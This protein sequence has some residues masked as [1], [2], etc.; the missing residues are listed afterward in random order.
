MDD[1]FVIV[2][3]LDFFFCPIDIV[4]GLEV[5]VCMNVDVCVYARSGLITWENIKDKLAATQ[6]TNKDK[7][8]ATQRT[9]KDN[10]RQQVCQAVSGLN[11][12]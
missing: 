12:K 9:N 11:Q 1:H 2:F 10:F 3:T 4:I 7:L 8:A 6:R 5:F